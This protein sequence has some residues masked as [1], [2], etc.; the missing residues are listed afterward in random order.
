LKL[1]LGLIVPSIEQVGGVHA[2]ARFVKD[3][4]LSSGR[5][6]L[7]LIS[8][9]TSAYDESSVE[10]SQPIS[11][12]RGVTTRLGQWQGLPFVHVG[13]VIGE[14]EFQRYRPRK[15]L[16]DAV[17]DCDILQVVSGSPATAYAVCGLGKPVS[18]QCA[19]RAR[20]ERRRR[21]ANPIGLAGWWRKAMTE[22]TDR[23]DDRALRVVDAIQVMN[24]WMYKYARQLNEGR[25]VDLR[26]APPGVDARSFCPATERNLDQDPYI[27]CVGRLDDPRKNI[28]LLLE[29]Y[30]LMPEH[31][32]NRVRL[33]LAGISGPPIGFWQRALV[34]G[35]RDQIT[36]IHHPS[37]DKL[38]A[39]YQQASMFALPS[40][41]EGLG[42]VLLEAMACGLAVVSTRSGGPDSLITDSEDGYLVP[43]DD[44]ATLAD[45]MARLYLDKKLNRDMGQRARATIEQ[46]YTDEIAGQAFLDVWD[47]LLHKAG[48]S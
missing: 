38:V 18:V 5:Y 40:D 17:S 14:L 8:L 44:P 36:F 22:I 3:V 21:D 24:P 12:G 13:A 20:V 10:I 26:Y 48:K 1:C 30:A 11:W 43:L 23:M 16:A 47:R 9:A 19:T 29:A 39:L 7:R 4:V 45:R 34:L 6:D 35:L 37:P 32:R 41:E 31:V 46:R 33:V 27:L 28:G 15:I 25:E 2:V 42:V